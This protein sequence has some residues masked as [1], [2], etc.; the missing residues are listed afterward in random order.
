MSGRSSAMTRRMISASPRLRGSRKSTAAFTTPPP[1]H[2]PHSGHGAKCRAL[3]RNASASAAIRDFLGQQSNDAANRG[4]RGSRTQES[5]ETRCGQPDRSNGAQ[6]IRFDCEH[7][8]RMVQCTGWDGQVVFPQHI[9]LPLLQAAVGLRAD[10]RP[11]R[12]RIA[13]DLAREAASSRMAAELEQRI[14][15]G[16]MA[17]A[18]LRALIYVRGPKAGSTSV[19]S[20]LSRRS[21][22]HSRQIERLG[23]PPEGDLRDQYLLMTL[24]QERAIR[25]FPSCCRM[26]PVGVKPQSGDAPRP[27]CHGEL[28]EDGRNGWPHRALFAAPAGSSSDRREASLQWRKVTAPWS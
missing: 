2:R 11:E 17:E 27:R 23:L 22:P 16:G 4:L 5:P 21:R 7:A 3:S 13:R 25:R 28:T 18:V 12:Q 24:N 6:H 8:R 1:S 26:I 19:A 10:R 9:R 14:D 20:G 15:Q